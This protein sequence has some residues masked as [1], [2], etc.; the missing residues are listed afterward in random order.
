MIGNH[1]MDIVTNQTTFCRIE[2][3]IHIT[4]LI[5]CASGDTISLST[6]PQLTIIID[7]QTADMIGWKSILYTVMSEGLVADVSF[8]GIYSINT[9]IGRYPQPA[10]L[11]QG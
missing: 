1:G 8:I 7:Q 11:I 6:Y 10:S 4:F 2:L 5:E 3:D 9:M